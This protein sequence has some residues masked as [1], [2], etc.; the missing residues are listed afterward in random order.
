MAKEI[1][2]EQIQ[3]LD[4][5]IERAR[6]ALKIIEGYDQERVDR[7]CQ[8][9]AAAVYPL[10]VWGPLCDSAVDESHL[11]DKVTKRNKRNKIKLILRDCLR[12]KS[13]GII[14]E[15]LND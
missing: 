9:V 12:Q 2:P 4:E 5:M 14:E 13:V 7:L 3:M 1:T 6:A 15:L 8:A 11:G 10:K